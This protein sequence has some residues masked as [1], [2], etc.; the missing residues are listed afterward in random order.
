M[1]GQVR[2]ACVLGF[3]H[4]IPMWLKEGS[5][6]EVFA[7]WE[8]KGLRKRVKIQPD[9]KEL[10]HEQEIAAAEPQELAATDEEEAEQPWHSSSC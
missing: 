6:R 10:Q 9:Q 1:P 4:Q 3:S 7:A 2:R 8:T 5:K